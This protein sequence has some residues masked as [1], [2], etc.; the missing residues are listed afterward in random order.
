MEISG[1]VFLLEP[2]GEGRVAN[3]VA[4]KKLALTHEDIS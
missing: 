1:R 3:G 2:S 4:R